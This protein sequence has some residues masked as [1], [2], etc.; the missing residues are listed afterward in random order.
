MWIPNKR[1][2]E[3]RIYNLSPINDLGNDS[4][5][6][7]NDTTTPVTLRER[8]LRPKGLLFL[9]RKILRFLKDLC[10]NTALRND[11][12]P[13]SPWE[14]S[15]QRRRVS[16]RSFKAIAGIQKFKEILD[17]L[18]KEFGGWR[19]RDSLLMLRMAWSKGAEFFN[20]R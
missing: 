19:H 8:F 9:N 13:P 7:W 11:I 18:W 5:T 2:W 16:L 6:A 10:Y 15:F 17:H 12:P 20:L 3:W 14:A 4:L 1:F